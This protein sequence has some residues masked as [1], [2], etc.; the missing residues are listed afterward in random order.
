MKKIYKYR[1]PIDGQSIKIDAYVIEWL[2][3][4]CQH[5]WPHIWAVV[6]DD[7]TP[8]ENEIVAW[9][10]GWPLPDDVYYGTDYLGT[11]VDGAGYVWHYFVQ[12]SS[13]SEQETV[14]GDWLTGRITDNSYDSTI[15]YYSNHIDGLNADVA[16]TAC[17]AADKITFTIS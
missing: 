15:T 1:L 14:C 5:G 11:A 2:E 6:D 17:N 16:V 8:V 10:T 13:K 9:G 4:H 12:T 7:F 3:I